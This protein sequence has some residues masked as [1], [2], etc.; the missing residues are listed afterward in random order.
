MAQI[1]S[2]VSDDNLQGKIYDSTLFKRLIKYL[3]PYRLYVIIS[4]ILLLLVAACQL[5]LPLIQMRAVDDIIASNKNMISFSSEEKLQN[6]KKKYD[7][8][9][10]D[11]YNYRENHML[12]FPNKNLDFISNEDQEKLKNNNQLS[13][14][15]I[16]LEDSEKL[17]SLQD[18]I[19]ST[20][21]SPNK[22]VVFS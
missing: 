18:K 22:V 9:K 13:H 19:K 3:K 12:I 11:E 6:F 10:F 15:I 16:V 4:F 1:Q 14:K 2:E 8:I 5:I 17:Q 7:N 21:L 20:Y